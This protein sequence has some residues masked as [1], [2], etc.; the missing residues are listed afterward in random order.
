MT[1]R[2]GIL[3]LFVVRTHYD[4]VWNRQQLNDGYYNININII[5]NI[6]INIIIINNNDDDICVTIS[7]LCCRVLMC[8]SYCWRWL[9]LLT[10]WQ[11]LGVSDLLCWWVRSSVLLPGVRIIARVCYGFY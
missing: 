2:L 11:T 7:L 5:I 10:D 6:N 9:V 1:I 4:V 8:H 3:L